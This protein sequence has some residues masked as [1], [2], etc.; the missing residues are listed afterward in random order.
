MTLMEKKKKDIYYI[1]K[2]LDLMRKSQSRLHDKITHVS[3]AT[4]SL[5]AFICVRVC[6]NLSSFASTVRDQPWARTCVHTHVRT[7][8]VRTTHVRTYVSEVKSI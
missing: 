4:M 6:L 8:H 7:T 3:I 1:L 2:V 5:S